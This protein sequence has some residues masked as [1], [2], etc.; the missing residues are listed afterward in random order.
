MRSGCY[1]GTFSPTAR[2]YSRAQHPDPPAI[3]AH[4]G[5]QHPDP[6]TVRAH[7]RSNCGGQPITHLDACTTY[8]DL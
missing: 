1:A 5:A 8:G 3:R 6:S 2:A 4:N 7:S